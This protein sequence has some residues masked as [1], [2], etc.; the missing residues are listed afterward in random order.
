MQHTNMKG[1]LKKFVTKLIFRFS[2]EGLE[3]RRLRKLKR[4]TPTQ[5]NL[6]DVPFQ[7]VDSASFVGQY[8]EIIKKEIYRFD[9]TGDAPTII[10]CGANVG[11]S[12]YYFK[13]RF[14]KANIIAFEADAKVFEVL[15]KNVEAMGS[16]G[17]VLKNEA[18]LNTEGL[19]NFYSD[20][21]D[22][23]SIVQGNS[24]G[25]LV[26]VQA[27]R[28][29]QYLSGKVDFLKLDIEGSECLVLQDCAD[30]LGNV[31]KIF[32][33]YHS[34]FN[35]KQDL[36]II[37]KLLSDNG[38]RY[39]IEQVNIFNANPFMKRRQL[40]QYDNLLNIYAHKEI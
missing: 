40:E 30:L 38:F 28:L 21:S 3:I 15:Q 5:T 24:K 8:F 34:V 35:K 37:L 25:K 7:L 12:I 23:G 6:L 31:D 2:K 19:V 10:D 26:Q 16:K 22:A 39:F 20:G 4:N 29:R 17:I 18:V 27:T 1:Y 36:D 14:P 33:E 11:S 13:K 32:I 9:A